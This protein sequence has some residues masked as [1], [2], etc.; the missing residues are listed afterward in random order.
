MGTYTGKYAFVSWFAVSPVPAFIDNPDA[1]GGLAPV[2]TYLEGGI[3]RF[4]S[5]LI[6]QPLHFFGRHPERMLVL[7]SPDSRSCVE[8]TVSTLGFQREDTWPS[9]R[10]ADGRFPDWPCRWPPRGDLCVMLSQ[11]SRLPKERAGRASKD[12]LLDHPHRG[13]G[14][15]RDSTSTKP[16]FLTSLSI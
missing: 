11:S 13:R 6:H 15:S 1:W 16:A 5:S 10:G 14:S 3:I 4:G 8:E 9:R 12:V 7:A 2:F